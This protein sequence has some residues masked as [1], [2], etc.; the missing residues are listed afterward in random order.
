MKK[1]L[2]TKI[3]FLILAL[4]SSVITQAQEKEN[5]FSYDVTVGI[6]RAKYEQ[7]DRVTINATAVSIGALI[8]YNLSEKLSLGTGAYYMVVDG[9]GVLSGNEYAFEQQYLRIPLKITWTD[10][11]QGLN[12]KNPTSS[13]TTHTY[14]SLG[15]YAGTLLK[16][17]VEFIGRNEEIK[18]GGW[19][20]GLIGEL[21][22]KF[23]ITENS[24]F[25][26][27]MT[28]WNDFFEMKKDNIK[29]ELDVVSTIGITF[30]HRF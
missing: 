9:N 10:F 6:G 2:F 20:M 12:N 22:A 21:G 3:I 24:Y 13:K 26:V 16:E 27:G 14:G 19:N 1:E 18:N 17:K 8:D 15:I 28:A 5:R 7:T 29:R 23:A 25:G 30:I 4:F 11:L